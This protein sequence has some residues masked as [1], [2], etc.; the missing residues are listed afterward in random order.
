MRTTIFLYHFSVLLILPTMAVI[1]F[2]NSSTPTRLLETD[3]LITRVP[4]SW[5]CQINNRRW[6]CREKDG[7]HRS[8]IVVSISEKQS[9]PEETL[10]SFLSHF[11]APKTTTSPDGQIITSTVTSVKKVYVN[12][13]PWIESVH[14]Q[15]EVLNYYTHYIITVHGNRTIF[16]RL[17]AHKDIFKS[18]EP[19]FIGIILNTRLKGGANL[20]GNE[21]APPP[22]QMVD[23]QALP[24]VGLGQSF[25]GLPR[26]FAFVVGILSCIALGLFLFR[27]KRK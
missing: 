9:S 2:A 10:D 12:N 22:A 3:Y 19:I 21:F 1:V 16:L 25:Q 13:I 11:E 23:Q 18:M 20:D 24:S 17:S 8:R 15:G 4:E 14:F 27:R 5:S 7:E 26:T 6:I